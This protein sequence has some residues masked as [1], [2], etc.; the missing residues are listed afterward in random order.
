MYRA[1]SVRLSNV[2]FPLSLGHITVLQFIYNNTQT[3]LPTKEALQD[4]VS[5]TFYRGIIVEMTYCLLFTHGWTQISSLPL[6]GNWADIM[7]PPYITLLSYII[8]CGPRG[9]SRITKTVLSLR[10]FQKYGGY[11]PGARK[12]D[13][14][15]RWARP[16]SSLHLEWVIISNT[17]EISHNYWRNITFL[18]ADSDNCLGSK[19]WQ[20]Y[21]K[22]ENC[23]NKFFLVYKIRRN[24]THKLDDWRYVVQPR[25]K[26]VKC[27]RYWKTDC[28]VEILSWWLQSFSLKYKAKS[29]DKNEGRRG[30]IAH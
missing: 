20:L 30:G 3:V 11:F 17:A 2:K 4:S 29:L 6:S 26:A 7:G 19:C 5:K 23:W 14:T 9:P 28:C 21:G 13:Q 27:L 12:K 16:N 25:W 10:K 24:I 15:Y 8:R 1:E 18:Y 22:G